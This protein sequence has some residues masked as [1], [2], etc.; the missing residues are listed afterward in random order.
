MSY[1][2]GMAGVLLVAY[3]LIVLEDKINEHKR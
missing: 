2:L 1:W 3:G